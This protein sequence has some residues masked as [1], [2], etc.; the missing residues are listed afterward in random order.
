[1]T[2][3]LSYI[4]WSFINLLS[5][6]LRV[7]IV[8]PITR[9]KEN[10]AFAFWHGE[11]FI[12]NVFHKNRHAVIMSSMSKDGAIQA[13]ILSRFK[14]TIVRG[15]SSRRGERAIVEMIRLVRRG[16]DTGFAVDGPKG[17]YKKA[18]PGIIYLAQKCGI[19][20]VPVSSCAKKRFVFNKAWDKYELP[21]PFSSA[22]WPMSATDISANRR[23]SIRRKR[24]PALPAGKAGGGAAIGPSS[25]RTSLFICRSTPP[26]SASGP[27]A[28]PAASSRFLKTVS[29]GSAGRSLQARTPLSKALRPSMA[30]GTISA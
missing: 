16:H 18:K 2:K 23:R 11:Q 14:Y 29:T 7:R 5:A 30:N 12:L 13:G 19:P 6:T 22:S 3:I 4:G 17:P 9:G 21:V 20:I 25:A 28:T 15:S 8:N 1:M 27:P 26:G 24:R 10:I